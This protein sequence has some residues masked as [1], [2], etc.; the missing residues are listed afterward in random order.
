MK[1]SIAL[2]L[3]LIF[4]TVVMAAPTT[5]PTV[6]STK[7][8]EANASTENAAANTASANQDSTSTIQS[9]DLPKATNI[10]TTPTAI[11]LTKAPFQFSSKSYFLAPTAGTEFAAGLSASQINLKFEDEDFSATSKLKYQ[12]GT[13]TIGHAL[14]S[15]TFVSANL[16]F[17]KFESESGS[18]NF[19]STEKGL[20]DPI[21]T[22]GHRISAGPDTTALM[23]LSAKINSGDSKRENVS[24]SE[25]K[26]NIKK[27]GNS[28]A[29]AIVVYKDLLN[30]TLG[31]A[32]AYEI[33]FESK[34]TSTA[35]T[36]SKDNFKSRGF[37]VQTVTAFVEIPQNLLS[38]G[39][40]I[41]YTKIEGGITEVDDKFEFESDDFSF[42]TVTGFTNIKLNNQ[43]SLVPS[44]SYGQIGEG[45]DK[46]IKTRDIFTASVMAKTAF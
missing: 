34:S 28:L 42:T 7:K 2:I 12:Y 9:E 32:L 21:L 35:Q 25:T 11:Y 24:D 45:L 1:A 18:G 6:R 38:L 4:S 16:G 8:T 37:N 10:S 30:A 36:G 31:A 3:T 46:S 41:E 39:A 5:A 40:A 44:L 17:G 33:N 14:N 22:A 29:P 23:T 19:K 15:Q 26:G 43:M 13:A 20:A 27:G